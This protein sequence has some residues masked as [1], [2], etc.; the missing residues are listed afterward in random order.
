[1][2]ILTL[3][4]LLSLTQLNASAQQITYNIPAGYENDISKEDYKTLVD[5]S[6][7]LISKKF[8]IAQVADGAV[9]LKPG[10]EYQV[11]NLHNLIT[12]CA[13]VKD[14]STWKEIIKDHFEKA[15]SS[16]DEEKRIDPSKYETIK[17]YLSIRI[18]PKS[19]VQQYGGGRLVERSDLEGTSSVLMLDLPSAFKTIN[20]EDFL[21]WKKDLTE[22]FRA[23]QDNV[24][25]KEMQKITQNI[26][27]DVGEI[28]MSVIGN[29][30]YAASYALDLQM[31]SP[32]LVG[33]WG[34]VI[35]IP[36]KGL[37]ELCKIS[38]DKPL[39]FVKF[40]QMTYGAV[41]KFYAEH[42]QPISNQFFWYY[43]G[44]FVKINVIKDANGNVSVISP[45]G[46]TELMT[47]K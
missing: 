39:D 14:K 2:R 32:E 18:Y 20:K 24:N 11:I 47:Q 26:K 43:K 38:K 29:E 28:E 13:A 30:D 23:A 37:A 45:M 31:N 19:Y 12:K 16:I 41:E 44:K 22:V 21:L 4:F 10:Q 5:L 3:L 34:S 17:K 27:V 8:S 42:P 1:M 40:I 36:N 9:Q 46:L 7:P 15:F 25:K 6:I 35:A 33:E